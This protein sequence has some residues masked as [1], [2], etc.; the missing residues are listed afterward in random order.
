MSSIKNVAIIMDGNGRWAKQRHRPRVWGHV[1]GSNKVNEI[2]SE[3]VAL[4]LESLTLYAFSTENWSRPT[5]EVKNLFK[6]LKKF[7]SREKKNLI[8][9]NI[10][11]DVIGNYKVL[12]TSI[13]KIIDEIKVKTEKNTGMI[14]S[15]AINYGG[16]A[17]IID[18][19]NKCLQKSEVNEIT[20]QD[21]TD[22]L[23]NPLVKNI[24]LLIRTAGDRRVSNFLLWQICYSEFFFTDTKWPDFSIEEYRNVLNEVGGRDRRF[25]GI[26]SGS[27]LKDN[28]KQANRNLKI[29]S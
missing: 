17:E 13:V 15:L 22:N 1:R 2:V 18:A 27:N 5:D 9:N 21:I 16:R 12:D 11:F 10:K 8:K 4:G 24:D 19:V 29:L 25:G 7:L 20:E 3:S 6:L 28:Q 14:L 23:Y 26:E